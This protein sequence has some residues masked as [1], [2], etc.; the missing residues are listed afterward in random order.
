MSQL[1]TAQPRR[2]LT[3]SPLDVSSGENVPFN[4]SLPYCTDENL[5]RFGASQNTRGAQPRRVLTD[6]ELDVNV[7]AA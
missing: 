1:R 4:L 2:V 7:T 3:R 6:G 5:R